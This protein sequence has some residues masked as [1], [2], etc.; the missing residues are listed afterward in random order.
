MTIWN[1]PRTRFPVWPMADM[2]I[3]LLTK[4]DVWSQKA[5]AH[6]QHLFGENL[7]VESGSGADPAP[8]SFTLVH[9]RAV[10][11]F[12]S[13]WIVPA[14]VLAKSDLALNFHPGSCDYPGIGCYNFA[15]YEEVAFFGSVCHYM[16]PKVDSGEVISETRF[17]VT[18][19]DRV[20]T[21]K[22]RTMQAMLEQ[23]KEITNLMV[24]EKPLPRHSRQWTRRAFTRAELNALCEILP[25]MS[26][27][28]KNRR[29]RATTYPGYPGPY[30]LVNGQKQPYPVPKGPAL[31]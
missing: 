4:K 13:P 23:F 26:E 12:L 30:L 28:E 19:D 21:L 17:P 31:A 14:E 6:A 7:I 16:L 1:A 25:D 15:L 20:E 24:T 29:I 8:K 18:A 2:P 22:L 11:S 27:A 5:V 10:L 9:F 3:L